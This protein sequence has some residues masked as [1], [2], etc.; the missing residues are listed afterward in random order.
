[1]RFAL[2]CC[3]LLQVACAGSKN[4]EGRLPPPATATPL[5]TIPY[6]VSG[7]HILDNKGHVFIPEGVHLMGLFTT[8]WHEALGIQHLTRKEMTAAHTFWHANTVAMQLASANL[9]DE[10]PYD[11]AYLAVVDQEVAWAHEEGMNI[12][13]VLQY[14]GT[15]RQP[16][17]TEDSIRFWNFMSLHYRNDPWVFFDVFN[18]PVRLPGM[19]ETDAWTFWQQGGNGYIGM[20][21]LVDA[22][23]RNGA[24]NLIFIDGLA[25]GEDLQGVPTHLIQGSNLVY[26][27]HPYLGNQHQTRAQWDQWFGRVAAKAN[28]PV[29]ADEW[30]SY[31]S[32]SAEC[33]LQAPT[34]V[35]QLLSYL[36]K[37]HIG[38]IAWALFPGLL[39][40]GW[41]F[42]SPTAYDQATYAC[43]APFPNYNPNAQGAGKEILQYLMANSKSSSHPSSPNV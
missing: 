41:D 6:S 37:L 28:F 16:L 8:N 19:T 32:A 3:I 30:N 10:N 36:D 26:A 35:P 12:L 27:I 1:M 31:Q 25:A 17:P 23:R 43:N 5:P 24:Q 21:E 18:E 2:L 15:T 29:V 7:A 33:V 40:R 34:L 4:S 20:Q 39:I 38:I 14:E 13:L 9:F 22:I 11:S 42:I